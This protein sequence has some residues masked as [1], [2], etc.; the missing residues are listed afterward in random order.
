MSTI[1]IADRGVPVEPRVVD[2]FAGNFFSVEVVFHRAVLRVGRAEN[3]VVVSA[4][5]RVRGHVGI[6]PFRFGFNRFLLRGGGLRLIRRGVL[7]RAGV[8]R[9]VGT[10]REDRRHCHEQRQKDRCEFFIHM[11]PP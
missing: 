4:E 5:I 2:G 10:C 8:F 1:L 3:G 11:V 6:Q 9:A 7:V